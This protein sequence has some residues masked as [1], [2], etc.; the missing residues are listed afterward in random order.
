MVVIPPG[1]FLMGSTDEQCTVAVQLLNQFNL[2]SGVRKSLENAERPQHRVVLSQP[3]LM[4]ATEVTLGEFKKFVAATGHQTESERANVAGKNPQP[5]YLTPGYEAKNDFPVVAVTWNDAVAYCEWLTAVGKKLTPRRGPF[6]LPDEA[7]WEKAARGTDGRRWP[8]EG[9]FDKTKL[10]SSEGGI[11]RTSA[12]GIFPAGKSPNDVYDCAGNVLEWCSGPGYSEDD[13]KYPLPQRLY[14]EDLNLTVGVRALRGGSWRD[15]DLNT[16]A[17]Y[18]SLN[19]PFFRN[20]DIGFRVA[21]L[22]SD[23]DF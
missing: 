2:N 23:S 19:L 6:R 8:W 12:V 13:A 7:M 18:R 17:A 21:E 5:T 4:G 22:L 3:F 11:G 16:R 15:I 10:N 9:E 20:L 1:E 14:K